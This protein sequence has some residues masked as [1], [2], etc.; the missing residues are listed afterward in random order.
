MIKQKTKK[1]V[2]N[3]CYGG[4]G[5]SEKAIEE[6]YKKKKMKWVDKSSYNTYFTIPKEEYDK[7]SKECYAKDGDYR[8]VNGKGYCL[9]SDSDIPRDDPVLIE[10]VEKMGKKANGMCADLEIVEIPEDVNFEIDEYD[11]M[12]SIHEVHRSWG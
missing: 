6:Y 2:I 3:N 8:N 9:I 1:V 11:G 7:I 12:E 4:F 10:I 5:L